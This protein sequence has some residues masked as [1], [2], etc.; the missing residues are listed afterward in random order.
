MFGVSNYLIIP[1]A[2][3]AAIQSTV[4]TVH[5]THCMGTHFVSKIM[6]DNVQRV[7][8][9]TPHESTW[10]VSLHDNHF[11]ARTNLVVDRHD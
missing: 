1:L 7:K 10:S 8:M 2:R 9:A 11:V 4:G 3:L 6:E 5:H